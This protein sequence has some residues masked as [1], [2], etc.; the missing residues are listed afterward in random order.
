MA[1]TREK[2]KNLLCLATYSVL[3]EM[4][5]YFQHQA[6]FAVLHLEG[7]EDGRQGALLK[8]HVDDGTDNRHNAALGILLALGTHSRSLSRRADWGK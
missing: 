4:L 3:A 2:K 1:D 8:G 5:S 6:V 7:V